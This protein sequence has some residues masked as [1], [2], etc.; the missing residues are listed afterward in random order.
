LKRPKHTAPSRRGRGSKPAVSST[1]AKDPVPGI[2]ENKKGVEREIREQK[3][4]QKALLD[5]WGV[6]GQ[7]LQEWWGSEEGEREAAFEASMDEEFCRELIGKFA[8]ESANKTSDVIGEVLDRYETIVLEL[9]AARY[10]EADGKRYS[11]GAVLYAKYESDSARKEFLPKFAKWIGKYVSD[12][13]REHS[14]EVTPLYRQIIPTHT[15]TLLDHCVDTELLTALAEEY[16]RD[17]EGLTRFL[18]AVF[19]CWRKLF[20]PYSP[21]RVRFLAQ[22][23]T[24][25][26]KEVAAAMEKIGAAPRNSQSLDDRV[27]QYRSRDQRSV[28]PKKILLRLRAVKKR[29]LTES[30]IF[31]LHYFSSAAVPAALGALRRSGQAK[32]KWKRTRAK[33]GKII[34]AK[35]WYAVTGFE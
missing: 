8:S 21:W 7:E 16:V 2:I 14:F 27:R 24:G 5:E 34:K 35:L 19:K 23:I 9:L 12:C 30:E 28:L 32:W 26:S 10:T 20:A 25:P 17:R 31:Q 13:I 15:W 4:K 11:L 3:E 6:T 22:Q 29:G 33:D 18:E 1:P